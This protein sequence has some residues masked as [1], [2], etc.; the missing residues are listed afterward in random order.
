MI[1]C[2]TM[3]RATVLCTNRGRPVRQKNMYLKNYPKVKKIKNDALKVLMERLSSTCPLASIVNIS[4][5]NGLCSFTKYR[6]TQK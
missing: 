6:G 5:L 1:S 3:V 2:S 4:V